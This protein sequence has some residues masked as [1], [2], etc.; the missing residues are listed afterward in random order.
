MLAANAVGM[1][2][3]P[4]ISDLSVGIGVEENIGWLDIAV[5]NSCFVGV[6]ETSANFYNQLTSSVL[7]NGRFVAGIVEGFSLDQLHDDVGHTV[8]LTKVVDSDEIRVI[9]LGHRAGLGLE[10]FAKA[11]VTEF[12]RQ[13]FNG[14]GTIEGNLF[15][16]VNGSHTTGGNQGT[17]IVTAEQVA[18][19]LWFRGIK[20]NWVAHL[21]LGK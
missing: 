16:G 9:E 1:N 12:P 11:F 19:F 4:K 3:E 6:G 8:G 21:K 18:Q 14:D 20:C 13:Q 7:F 17:H 10:L 2:G 15:R 5:D